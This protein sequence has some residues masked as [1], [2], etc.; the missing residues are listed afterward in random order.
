MRCFQVYYNNISVLKR[1]QDRT[2]DR[3]KDNARE[4]ANHMTVEKVTWTCST[5][6]D[7]TES[8]EISFLYD[9]SYAVLRVS[10]ISSTEH[11]WSFDFKTTERYAPLLVSWTKSDV[12]IVEILDSKVRVLAGAEG[13]STELVAQKNISDGQWHTLQLHRSFEK[14]K[15]SIIG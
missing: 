7:A 15:V 8:D 10:D 5:E 1:A 6:F 3:A 11:N 13:Q 12:F 2:K 14:L 4:H 9:D